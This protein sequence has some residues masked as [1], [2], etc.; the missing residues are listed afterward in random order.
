MDLLSCLLYILFILIDMIAR[1]ERSSLLYIEIG[2]AMTLS[3]QAC[4]TAFAYKKCVIV[5]SYIFARYLKMLKVGLLLILVILVLISEALT[6]VSNIASGGNCSTLVQNK[7]LLFYFFY[8]PLQVYMLYILHSF[9][10]RGRMG[11]FDSQ[12]NVLV[13]VHGIDTQGT[14][15]RVYFIN[16]ERITQNTPRNF[17]RWGGLILGSRTLRHRGMGVCSISKVQAIP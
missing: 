16:G 8:V 6:C 12:G 1:S 11:H 13:E 3:L 2:K 14:E 17:R 9:Y 4:C 10:Y 7:K 5:R 15:I